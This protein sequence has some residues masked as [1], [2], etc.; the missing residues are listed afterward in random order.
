[1]T[2]SLYSVFFLFLL[3]KR[4]FHVL[5]TCTLVPDGGGHVTIPSDD[6]TW[7]SIG[8]GYFEGCLELV[9]V[10]I[11][12]STTTV[13]ENAFKN[14]VNLVT[15]SI[16]DTLTTIGANAFYGCTALTTMPGFDTAAISAIGDDA[17]HYCISL[18][19]LRCAIVP[20]EDGH[21]SI[22]STWTSV[23]SFSFFGCSTLVSLNF[24]SSVLTIESNSFFGCV[25]LAALI[26]PDSV[27][28][29]GAK[30]FQYAINMLTL[31]IGSGVTNID[32]SAFYGC[33]Q[34]TEVAL[35]AD[36]E[37]QYIGRYV[38]GG[39]G[40]ISGTLNLPATITFIGTGAFHECSLWTIVIACGTLASI[41]AMPMRGTNGIGD[42]EVHPVLS[43]P[44]SVT[45]AG[46]RSFKSCLCPL[47]TYSSD[48]QIQQGSVTG[49]VS[50]GC[51]CTACP[52]GY[53]TRYEGSISEDDSICQKSECAPGYVGTGGHGGNMGRKPNGCTQCDVGKYSSTLFDCP[54]Y[55]RR[56]S[57]L[58][59]AFGTDCEVQETFDRASNHWFNHGS[60]LLE[61]RAGLK[62][63]CTDCDVGYT[64]SGLSAGA[65]SSAACTLC[66]AGYGRSTVGG[67]S[68]CVKCEKGTISQAGDEQCTLCAAGKYSP[69]T[70]RAA[71]IDCGAG[72][73]SD[74]VGAG[75]G[76]ECEP[77]SPGQYS[78]AGATSCASCALGK[79]S[80]SNWAA[81]TLCPA[82]YQTTP[83]QGSC[84][85]CN[86]GT[87]SA[88]GASACT[89]CT[90]GYY[91]APSATECTACQA[92]M[93]SDRGAGECTLCPRGMFSEAGA[94]ECTPCPQGF[95]SNEGASACI[96]CSV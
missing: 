74:V 58:R 19:S 39:D 44:L 56:Y 38:F 25:N 15:V 6:P 63:T 81:C 54:S 40:S 3:C 47:N 49:C 34:L 9:S 43:L 71:C 75:S 48:G 42:N 7:A 68:I 76:L 64:T 52:A 60:A 92:G 78:A 59:N 73:S 53:L 85:S 36:S 1:M 94:S 88:A 22:P 24:P 51:C 18:R 72:K 2:F 45:Y 79:Y 29:I 55:L 27:T 13:E 87:R 62:D 17:F 70:G 80:N 93:R 91:S 16:P 11:P 10:N 8:T 35:A 95:I 33:G 28:A 14:C 90:A 20:N 32:D 30:A 65:D 31:S 26:V 12:F 23:P 37:L 21:V 57:D 89:V 69:A 86:A 77:C 83:E 84:V 4:A 66:A 96:S 50:A 46:P 67:S 41:E 5:A 82:G 61:N